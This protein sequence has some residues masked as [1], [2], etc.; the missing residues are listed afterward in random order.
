MGNRA[1]KK[2]KKKKRREDRLRKEKHERR[3]QPRTVEYADE[4]ED[5]RE[6]TFR[7]ASQPPDREDEWEEE[8]TEGWDEDDEFD[9]DGDAGR[10]WYDEHDW[11]G[12]PCDEAFCLT[13]TD[14]IDSERMLRRAAR[15]LSEKRAGVLE[16]VRNFLDRLSNKSGEPGSPSLPDDPVERGQELAF[17]ALRAE[18]PSQA[19]HLAEKALRA[20]PECL[21]ALA[22]VAQHKHEA[23]PERAAEF[24]RIVATGERRLGGPAFFAEHKGRFWNRVETRPYMRVREQWAHLLA[25]T[26]RLPAAVAHYEALLDLDPLD[27]LHVRVLL[28]CRYLELGRLDDAKRIMAR[29]PYGRAAYLWARVLGQFLTG[30]LVAASRAHSQALLVNDFLETTIRKSFGHRPHQ[31]D[32]CGELDKADVVEISLAIAW[33]RHPKALAWMM[34][35]SRAFSE[36]EVE[37]HRASFSPPVSNL[38]LLE[39]PD[40]RDWLDYPATHGFTEAHV[41]ELIRMATDHALQESDQDHVLFGAV[42]AWRALAQLRAQAAIAPLLELFAANLDDWASNDFPRIFELLGPEAISGLRTLLVERHGL[43]LRSITA[44]ALSRI[45]THHPEAAGR[46]V[47][48]L[49]EQLHRYREN[50]RMLNECLAE[51]LARLQAQ[52]AWPVIQEAIANGYLSE[53]CPLDLRDFA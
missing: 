45:G 39:G 7:N 3:A 8:E 26:D 52:E 10:G 44:Q 11:N 38:F 23:W 30:D 53:D 14:W 21:D 32:P 42:H 13:G 29:F 5:I 18:N 37:A 19:L 25:F 40:L 49:L 33:N 4:S 28:L 48:V 46:C 43:D 12:D 15:I 24:E 17:R 41:P 1:K 31:N 9:S 20:D 34:A 22:I 16:S 2:E 6:R 51:C 36:R 27:H 35:S 50:H 47:E